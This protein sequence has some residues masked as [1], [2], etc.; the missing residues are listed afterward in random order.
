MSKVTW[1]LLFCSTKSPKLK[2]FPFPNRE[3]QKILLFEGFKWLIDYQIIIKTDADY[4]SVNQ[5]IN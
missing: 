4:F 2:D 3:K 1:N 5:L